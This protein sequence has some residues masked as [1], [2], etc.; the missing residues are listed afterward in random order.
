MPYGN[1]GLH[2]GEIDPGNTHLSA[3]PLDAVPRPS[4]ETA[5]PALE[6]SEQ[7]SHALPRTSLI[8]KLK[9]WAVR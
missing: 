1:C 8:R 2:A 3:C 9:A 5:N 6:T 7:K 4:R